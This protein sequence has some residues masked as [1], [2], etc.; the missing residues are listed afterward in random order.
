MTTIG[1][2][3][4]DLV[5]DSA[6][7][8]SAPELGG[9]LD[10]PLSRRQGRRGSDDP[11]DGE[12]W[13]PPTSLAGSLRAHVGRQAERWFGSNPPEAGR[14][15]RG[16][17]L[18]PS[19]VRF[20]GSQT[21]LPRN[22]A[23]RRS[24]AI[25]PCRGSALASTLRS[26]EMAP[27]GTT[28]SLFL[29]LDQQGGADDL[30]EFAHAAATWRPII[31][32]GR[33]TGHGRATVTRIAWRR[34]DLRTTAGLR[35]WLT[36]G[37]EGL[38]PAGAGWEK[39]RVLTAS[40]H[41]EPELD[42]RFTIISALHIGAGSE[43][44]DDG[45]TRNAIERDGDSP[46]LPGTAWKGL[47]R[48]RCGYILRSCGR[49]A[50]LAPAQRCCEGCLLCDLFGYTGAGGE[51]GAPL[52]RAGRLTT[53]D[54]IIDGVVTYRNHV[55]IDRFT[56]G[57]RRALLFS[58][59]VVAEGH[60]PLC[61]DATDPADRISPARLSPAERG[62]LLLAIRDLHDGLIGVGHATTRGYGSLQLTKDSA[63]VLDELAPT[64]P[65]GSAVLAL[66]RGE[67]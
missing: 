1:L 51:A 16:G 38:F 32:G 56:G 21:T 13:I 53:R 24:T 27:I 3:R 43:T 49:P 30:D 45:R 14:A 6:G 52:G 64:H 2:I 18:E 15:D 22:P 65:T 62:L 46:L 29:R 36:A 47:L 60:L 61:L 25:D 5:L 34:L 42:L 37:R 12:V 19:P 66:L 35:A 55:G 44:A 59:E 11:T 41:R 67:V 54:S 20:L 17:K 31:G 8:V 10:L 58:D 57:A 63:V 48:S 39:V 23:V 7:G 28:V 40:D 9:A 4:I 33:S 50:C 26:R